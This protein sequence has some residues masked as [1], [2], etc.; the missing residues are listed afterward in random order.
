MKLLASI[1]LEDEGHLL[2]KKLQP[3]LTGPRGL[4]LVTTHPGGLAEELDPFT[5][6]VVLSANALKAVH[7]QAL[8][9]L[10]ERGFE[11]SILVVSKIDSAAALHEINAVPNSFV[12]ERPYDPRDLVGLVQKCIH[13]KQVSQRYHRRFPTKASAEVDVDGIMVR[14]VVRNLSRG[15]AYL[16][17]EDGPLPERGSTVVLN[18]ALKDV[19]RS[20]SMPAKVVW[21]SLTAADGRPGLGVEF[22]GGGD[23]HRLAVGNG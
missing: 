23:V 2:R 5:I 18:I 13:E 8:R 17:V 4:E 21:V 12:L 3:V 16:E 20:Y 19:H 22:I 1:D 6:M 9:S 14:S 15:G 11:G 7:R 10:R